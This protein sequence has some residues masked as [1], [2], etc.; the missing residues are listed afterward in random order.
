VITVIPFGPQ[1]P[2]ALEGALA[3]LGHPHR[4]AVRPDQAAPAG[5]LVLAGTGPL[6]LACAELKAAGWWLDLPDLLAGGRGVLGIGAGLHLLAEGS[7]ECPRGSGLGL[8]PGIVRRLGPGVRVPHFGWSPVRACR[9]HPLLSAF[10]D[11]WLFFAHCHALDPT[12][13]TLA[14]AVHGRPFAVLECRGRAVGLQAQPEKS[15]PA[16]LDLLAGLL[17][18]MGEFPESRGAN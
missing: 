7:E 18:A 16:G 5:P 13:E 17:G 11:D 6:D 1:A 2:V 9:T 12:S 14:D 10:R 4:R 15:G 8:I 3:R